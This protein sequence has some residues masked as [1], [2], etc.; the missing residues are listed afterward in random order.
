MY[1]P[2]SGNEDHLTRRIDVFEATIRQTVNNQTNY[3]NALDA[4]IEKLAERIDAR[5]ESDLK[6]MALTAGELAGVKADTK[7]RLQSN[8]FAFAAIGHREVLLSLANEIQS[9]ADALNLEK[10]G[11]SLADPAVFAAWEKDYSAWRGNLEQWLIFAS[12]YWPDV[13]SV[14]KLPDN[15]HKL[16]WT[17]GDSQ[18]PSSAAI[19]EYRTF[20]V[21]HQNWTMMRD[22]VHAGVRKVAFEGKLPVNAEL[23]N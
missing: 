16:S 2:T 19:H 13:Q 14:K 18:F 5:L 11:D 1:A 20:C 23:T 7:K 9:G 3:M 8:D 12:P 17:F 4:R 10:R 21:L 22:N 6:Q 15:I